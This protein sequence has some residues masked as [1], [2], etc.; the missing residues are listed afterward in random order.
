M[1]VQCRVNYAEA[2]C[3]ESRPPLPLLLRKKPPRPFRIPNK[4]TIFAIP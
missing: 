1:E 3:V 2:S 4:F